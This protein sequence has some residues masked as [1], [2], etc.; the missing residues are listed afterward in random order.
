MAN[1]SVKDV[2]A[3]LQT[4]TVGLRREDVER[5]RDEF[6]ENIVVH[7]Q[8]KSIIVLL[9]NAFINPFIGVLTVL[10]IISLILDVLTADPGSK[11]WTGPIIISVMVV[12]STILRFWQEWKAGEATEGLM[13]M[14]KNT[15]TVKRAEE[16]TYQE[17]DIC[18][19]VPGDM[20][21]LSAGD[22]VPADIRIVENKD[23]FVSQAAL[24]GEAEP[25]E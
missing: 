24:S 7:E 10:V 8:K 19:L 3:T 20:V 14:V 16:S 5:R 25:V 15:C 6:G 17:I 23:L 1:Q 12:A 11:D 13:K 4:T 9:C 2:F 21:Y 22:M 18:E